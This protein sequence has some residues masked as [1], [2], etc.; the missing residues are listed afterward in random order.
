M[1]MRVDEVNAAGVDG[2]GNVWTAG[3]P[4][5]SSHA[6]LSRWDGASWTDEQLPEDITSSAGSSILGIDGVPGTRGVLA[7]G[8]TACE[9]T[10]SG[11]C[12]LVVSR[13]ID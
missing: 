9:N 6:V 5:G 2:S 12:G 8:D 10:A 4:V 7:A 1:R 11:A 3:W 13:G